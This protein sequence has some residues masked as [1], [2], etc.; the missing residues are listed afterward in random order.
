MTNLND[1][2]KLI[3]SRIY[4]IRKEL[5]LS[6]QELGFLLEV[7]Y[8]YV[9]ALEN[10]TR[11]PGMKLMQRIIHLCGMHGMREVDNHYLRPDFM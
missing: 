5:G 7:S 1:N 10:G 8:Q 11:K 6:Q 4:S 9:S 3:A 2:D